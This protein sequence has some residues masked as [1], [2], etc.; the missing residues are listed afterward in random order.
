MMFEIIISRV[1]VFYNANV[2]DLNGNQI[3]NRSD[4]VNADEQRPFVISDDND[5]TSS[6]ERSQKLTC[7]C[8]FSMCSLIS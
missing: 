5:D 2:N 7:G 6:N 4:L 3:K 8:S 1:I